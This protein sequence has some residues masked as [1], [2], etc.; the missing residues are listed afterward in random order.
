MSDY[1]N[2]AQLNS[3]LLGT[4]LVVQTSEAHSKTE[5]VC[6]CTRF[7]VFFFANIES[8]RYFTDMGNEKLLCFYY[9][10]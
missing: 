6:L 8:R 9:E 5:S 10:M 1:V 7:L 3:F 2:F 4:F